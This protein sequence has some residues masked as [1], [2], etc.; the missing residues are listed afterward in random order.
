MTTDLFVIVAIGAF[1]VFLL[2]LRSESQAAP[3]YQPYVPPPEPETPQLR[4][5]SRREERPKIE[6]K[7]LDELP[8][9]LAGQEA[10]ELKLLN[11]SF[12][13]TDWRMGPPDAEDF[14]DE[15]MVEFYYPKTGERW[16]QEFS[17]AT[18]KGL[19][20]FLRESGEK[21]FARGD[22]FVVA[23]FDRELIAREI[24]DFVLAHIKDDEAIKEEIEREREETSY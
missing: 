8:G 1:V 19:A 14:L 2:W 7:Y 22:L 13:R 18:P 4:V 23:R 5:V 12:M 3:P 15:I 21:S 11:Y 10:A 9:P 16:T 24:R 17:V 20:R 6:S